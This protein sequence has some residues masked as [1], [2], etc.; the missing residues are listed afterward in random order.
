MKDKL[1]TIDKR[2]IYQLDLNPRIPLTTLAKKLRINRNTLEYRIKKLVDKKI[3]KYF[4]TVVNGFN[5]GFNYY[6]YYIKIKRINKEFSLSRLFDENEVVWIG[7]TDGY[8]DFAIT[9][10]AKNHVDILKILT[11]INTFFEI[12][13]KSLLQIA[14]ASVFNERW[15]INTKDINEIDSEMYEKIPKLNEKDI[16]IIDIL[17]VNARETLV[18]IANLINLTP[19]AVSK[20]IKNLK[21]EKIIVGFKT[22]IN[23][24]SLGYDY[25][26]LLLALDKSDFK[27]KVINLLKS[28]ENC[29]LVFETVGKYD[30]Q[31]EFIAKSYQEI[32]LFI[33]KLKEQFPNEIENIERLF[34]I[35]ESKIKTM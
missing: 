4:F 7:R 21:R 19:E 25:Y 26:H 28:F 10:R 3:I 2:I 14:K 29:V 35:E 12:K 16:K 32:R 30:I 18:N 11:K 17:S 15:L 31:A 5:L 13:E 9:L 8:W 24:P 27:K 22:R 33:D 34:I 1:S 23:Y 6:K 20:R